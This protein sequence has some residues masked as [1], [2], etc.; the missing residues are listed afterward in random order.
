VVV[1]VVVVAT[2]QLLAGGVQQAKVTREGAGRTPAAFSTAVAAVVL[3]RLGRAPTAPGETAGMGSKQ[4]SL[5]PQLITLA[6][7]VAVLQ[8]TGLAGLVVAVTVGTVLKPVR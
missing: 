1:P 7:A 6:A 2:L 4:I 5:G 8:V 3:V